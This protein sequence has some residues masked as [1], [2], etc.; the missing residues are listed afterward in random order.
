MV[1]HTQEEHPDKSPD[2]SMSVVGVYRRP[3]QRQTKEGQMTPDF[4]RGDPSQREGGVGTEF[5]RKI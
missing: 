4:K 5:A 1:E 3:L 2:F